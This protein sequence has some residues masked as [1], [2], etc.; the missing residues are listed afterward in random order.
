MYIWLMGYAG[1]S[2]PERR[3]VLDAL[4]V[5]RQPPFGNWDEVFRPGSP[6]LYVQHAGTR[7]LV[8]RDR[9][10][11]VGP[12][13][14]VCYLPGREYPT[15]RPP[16]P[17]A[18]WALYCSPARAD[19]WYHELPPGPG[20]RLLIPF[21]TP[22]HGRPEWRLM[23]EELV[24]RAQS[25]FPRERLKAE[26]LL[27]Q[28][29]AELSVEPAVETRLPHF[30]RVF[31]ELLRAPWARRPEKELAARAHLSRST[32]KRAFK[33]RTGVGLARF[34]QRLILGE[35]AR[36]LASPEP[37]KLTQLAEMLGFFDAFH[38][39]RAF[40]QALGLSPREYRRARR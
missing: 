30:D 23:A 21:H 28:L 10:V 22:G 35:A 26:A 2:L 37:P 13:D 19:R 33:A 8:D 1:L 5:R 17:Y 11:E 4:E 29:L 6:Y 39:S 25:G 15:P 9:R 34:R 32:F 14:V 27:A 24:R 40:K 18:A 7:L 38:F 3:R 20:Q 16:G 31:E 12:G 36:R